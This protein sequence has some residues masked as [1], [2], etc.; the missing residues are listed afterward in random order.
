M[1]GKNSQAGDDLAWAW[2]NLG[3]AGM[4]REIVQR[5]ARNDV[6]DLTAIFDEPWDILEVAAMSLGF[7]DAMTALDLCSDAVFIASGRPQKE[8]G[9]AYDIGELRRQRST[10]NAP[11]AIQAWI[12]QLCAHPDL[13]LLEACRHPLTHRTVRRHIAFNVTSSVRTPSEITT[14]HGTAAPQGRGPIDD[15]IPRLVG[16]AEDQLERLCQAILTDFPAPL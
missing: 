13:R 6:T 5:L 12:D 11:A 16:F 14:L 7:E 15:L 2:F 8:G 10:L 3:A 4:G 9:Y 1:G